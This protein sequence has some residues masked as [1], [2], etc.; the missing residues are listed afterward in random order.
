MMPV[1]ERLQATVFV[2]HFA[3][4]D[5]LCP[6]AQGYRQVLEIRNA[7]NPARYQGGCKLDVRRVSYLLCWMLIVLQTSI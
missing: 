4:H 1:Q 5:L 3:V 6:A 2:L 7:T